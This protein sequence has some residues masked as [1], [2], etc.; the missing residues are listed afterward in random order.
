MNF[1][2]RLRK[3]PEY[4][5]K[6]I[7]WSIIVIVGLGLAA[8]WINLSRRKIKEFNKEKFIEKINLPSFKEAG[9]ENLLE[10]KMPEIS[11]EELKKSMNNEQ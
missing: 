3:Q 10:I 7:L 11:E 5:R 9:L 8:W 4:I 1:I 6:I 2:E